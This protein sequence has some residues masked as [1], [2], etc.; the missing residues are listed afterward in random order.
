[1]NKS[2]KHAFVN[3]LLVYSLVMICLTGS[4][5]LATVWMRQQMAQT[6]QRIKLAE[7]R[8]MELERRLAELGSL[9]AGEQSPEVLR[10]RNAQWKLGLVAPRE[11]QLVRVDERP[12]QR[13]AAKRNAEVF[14]TQPTITPVNLLLSDAR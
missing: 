1:M 11:E 6:A 7:N 3:H 4:I 10:R 13:L 9:I 2:D 14:G 8:T 12:E 5:G